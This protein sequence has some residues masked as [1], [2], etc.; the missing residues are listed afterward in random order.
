MGFTGLTLHLVPVRFDI[1]T[2]VVG[3]KATRSLLTHAKVR[4]TVAAHQRQ[5]VTFTRNSAPLQRISG[6][7]IAW[8]N[9]GSAWNSPGTSARR[10]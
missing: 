2:P 1:G 6:T 8:P 4:T 7:Y 9:T 5:S 3:W 10:S